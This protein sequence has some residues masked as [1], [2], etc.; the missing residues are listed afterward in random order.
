MSP[1]GQLLDRWGVPYHLHQMSSNDL[2]FRSA[3]PDREL[4]TADDLVSTPMPM[5]R[6][7]SALDFQPDP[8]PP[9]PDAA[10]E[11]SPGDSK[12][13]ADFPTAPAD[14]PFQGG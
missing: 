2:D 9:P 5:P 6:E 11:T 4:F 1:D 14:S 3:G 12:A 13:T 7:I 8:L 10:S